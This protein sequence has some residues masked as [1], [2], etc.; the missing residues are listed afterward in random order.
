MSRVVTWTVALAMLVAAWFVA[1]ATP[2]GEE[3]IGDPFPVAA[4]LGEPVVADTLAVTV[5]SVRLAERVEAG[6]WFA[7]GTWLVVT[8]DASLVGRAPMALRNVYLR[9]GERSFLASERVRGFDAD[10]ALDGRVLH[11]GIPQSGTLVVE[12]PVDITADAHASEAALQL[13]VGTA[14]QASSPDQN[15]AGA[16][17]VELPVDLTA[18]DRTDVIELPETTWTTP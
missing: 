14:V 6:G 18:L 16:A 2:D 15:H 3:R 17:V 10:A 9:V 4:E 7:D 8:L 1:G 12:L 5:Q 11:V 13:A